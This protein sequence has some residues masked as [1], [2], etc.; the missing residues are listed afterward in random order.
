MNW[1][2]RANRFSVSPDLSR[3]WIQAD[4]PE[5]ALAGRCASVPTPKVTVPRIG[6]RSSDGRVGHLAPLDAA[7]RRTAAA[8][9]RWQCDGRLKPEVVATASIEVAGEQARAIGAAGAAIVAL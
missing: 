6:L 3:V 2:A 1:P 7:R 8:P 4:L 9:S 5:S